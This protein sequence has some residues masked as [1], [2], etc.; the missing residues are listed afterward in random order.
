MIESPPIDLAGLA[1]LDAVVLDW[2]HKAIG[3]AAHGMR[4]AEFLAGH[5]RLSD[6]QTPLLTL[7]R[8]ALTCNRELMAGWCAESGVGIAPH[9]KTTMAP[10]LWAEQLA[11]GAWGIT[12]ANFAQLR[13]AHAFGVRCVQ[14][15]NSLT[16]PS[17][18]AWAARVVAN[19][20]LRLVSWVDAVD[21]V[22]TL[23]HALGEAVLPVCVE[24]GGAGG[25]TGA[26]GVDA[27]LA[28]ARAVA[29]A[30]GL[31]LAGVAG[32]E[33]ALAHD[34]STA[35]LAAVE[36]FLLAMRALHERLVAD[37]LYETAE[38]LVTA[39]GS[40]YFDQVARILAPCA[41]DSVR[42]LVRAGAYLIH[43]DGFYRALSPLRRGGREAFRSAMHAWARVVSAPE[44]GLA[45]LDAG[46]RDLSFDEG[47][48]EPQRISTRLGGPSRELSGARIDAV[49]DQH[50]FLRFDP[51]TVEVRIG[52]VIRLGLSHPCT[53]LDKWTIIPVLDAADGDDPLVLDLVQTFF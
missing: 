20:E 11:A 15:A 48:P 17:A 41:S 9:G 16:D 28:V 53:A 30:P 46:K 29:A 25:R 13:V 40:A 50:A 33:G 4:C 51:A 3:P 26:R 32:Y 37:D 44:P 7:D 42:V 14:L 2:R 8:Q 39:G 38:V 22:E 52:D 1:E 23:Q 24:L 34:A 21:T 12:L 31:R 45:L 10:S 43:D 5:P 6:F 35:S 36:E 47:L 27:A 19:D 49:N 18:I